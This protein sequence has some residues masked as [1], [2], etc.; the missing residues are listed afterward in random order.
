[1]SANAATADTFTLDTFRRDTRA[2]LEANC[3]PEMRQPVKSEG[4]VCWGGK[5]FKFQSEAQ[6]QWMQRMAERGWTVPHVAARIR[7]RRAVAP[8]GRGAAR[9][10]GAR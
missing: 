6:R 9:G 4:D 10:D 5:R 7:R 8:R 1:M 2:W 3:P